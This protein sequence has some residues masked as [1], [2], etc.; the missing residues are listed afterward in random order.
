MNVLFR[1]TVAD[2]VSAANG[3]LLYGDQSTV[4]ESV[5]SDSRDIG[6]RALFV[7]IVGEN[8]DGHTF[9][10]TLCADNKISA[11]LTSRERDKAAAAVHDIPAI[12]CDD[13]ILALGRIAAKH[14]SSFSN[15]L[16]GI[17]GTNGK[18]TTKELVSAILSSKGPVLKSDKNY[19]NEI[20]VPFTLFGLSNQ[21]YAVIEM[22]MNH[23]GEISR[24][25]AM[26]RPDVAIITNAG[27]GHLEFLGSVEN[28]AHAKSEIMEGMKAGS[29][30]LLNEE[31]EYVDLMKK[32]A[33]RHSLKVVTFGVNTGTFR[34]ESFNLGPRSTV[35]IYGGIRFDVPLFG[36]HNV[37]NIMA[38]VACSEILGID[39]KDAA[40]ALA[41]FENV[42]KRN[43]II[44]KEYVVVND[45][46]NSNPLSLRYALRSLG[47]IYKGRRTIAVLSD[48]KELGEHTER[49]HLDSGREVFEN[50]FARLYTWGE[51]SRWI[52]EGALKAGMPLSDVL[53][54]SSKDEL[55]HRLAAD[56]KAGDAVLVKGSRSMKM[57]EVADALVR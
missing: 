26:A 41:S 31:S 47:L 7:P 36:M 9:V 52:A 16:V 32:S 3:T 10:D 18:T 2:L 20:G 14:R 33:A 8:F 4:I 17:T 48:M 29:T 39:L 49:C 38:A 23:P 43:D 44:E 25:T 12:L 46:Y 35:F 22:G 28:V 50:N 55:I 13:T 5:T 34:P 21:Q 15:T 37:S 1:S 45:T 11:F 27:E 24:L 30:I 6:I 42:G 19:N 57:E 53:H 56:V 51:Y 54:F 40:S